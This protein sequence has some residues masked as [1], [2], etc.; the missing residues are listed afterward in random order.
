VID[1]VGEI[2]CGVFGVGL[3]I[4]EGIIDD[5]GSGITSKDRRHFS[6]RQIDEPTDDQRC[7]ISKTLNLLETESYARLM[8]KVKL[9]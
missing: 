5:G 2:S 3:V 7:V 1:K 8:K 4:G 9:Y 6:R